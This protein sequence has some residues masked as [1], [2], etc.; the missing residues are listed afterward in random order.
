[1]KYKVYID[2]NDL[3]Y[4]VPDDF[5]GVRI[6]FDEKS[7]KANTKCWAECG[8]T[9]VVLDCSQPN[10]IVKE[11]WDLAMKNAVPSSLIERR[12]ILNG[13]KAM[14]KGLRMAY[15]GIKCTYISGPFWRLYYKVRGKR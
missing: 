15:W 1:L 6:F 12:Y 10:I 14:Y 2:G 7:I 13:L 3:K 9:Q 11:D 5:H 8:I 4:H